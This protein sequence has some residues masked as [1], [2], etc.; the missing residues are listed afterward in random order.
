M[1]ALNNKLTRGH[2][3]WTFQIDFGGDIYIKIYVIEGAD[4]EYHIENV[5]G[6]KIKKFEEKN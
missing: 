4:Y 2:Q 5:V 3:S 6:Q 1:K